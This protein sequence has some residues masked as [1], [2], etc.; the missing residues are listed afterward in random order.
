MEKPYVDAAG[1]GLIVTMFYPLWDKQ[2]NQFAG[3]VG[4]DI[5]LNKIVENILSIQFAKTGFAFLTDGQGNI[6]AMP[7]T[8]S[9]LFQVNFAKTELGSLVYYKGS[10]ADS[11][12]P[13]VKELATAIQANEQGYQTISLTDASGQL[14]QE[15]LTYNSLPA[16]YDNNYQVDRWKIVIVVPEEEIF[17][18]I[19]QTRTEIQQERLRISLISLGILAVFLVSLMF[20]FGLHGADLEQ[21]R[22]IDQ[23]IELRIGRTI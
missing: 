21:F 3:A 2:N 18:A 12:N 4:I 5:T 20:F 15:M 10:L 11:T 14:H 23:V 22:L 8:G 13:A 16:L 7:E 9:R 17:A 1:Q 19:N 6:I